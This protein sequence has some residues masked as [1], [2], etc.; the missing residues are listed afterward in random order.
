MKWSDKY[1][2]FGQRGQVI[3]VL[4]RRYRALV[5][6]ITIFIFASAWGLGFLSL[7]THPILNSVGVGGAALLLCALVLF[8]RLKGRRVVLGHGFQSASTKLELRWMLANIV[9]WS[10]GILLFW[11]ILQMRS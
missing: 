7:W 10:V 1:R 6:R 4:P 11:L 2:Y 8:G 5:G 9:V 3:Y